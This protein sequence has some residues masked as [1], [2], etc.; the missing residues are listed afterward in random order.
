MML[1]HRITSWLLKVAIRRAI[2]SSD[3]GTGPSKVIIN[4][5][6]DELRKVYTDDNMPTIYACI[7]DAAYLSER[8]TGC[9]K[10]LKKIWEENA[11][12]P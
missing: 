3:W 8:E 4:I 10:V 9:S 5:L 12:V 2:A 6:R 7:L 1:K 11:Q